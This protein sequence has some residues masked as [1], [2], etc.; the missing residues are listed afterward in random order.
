M[1]SA[2]SLIGFAVAW[3]LATW[4]TALI[5]GAGVAI[6]RPRLAATGPAAERVAAAFVL[7]GAPLGGLVVAGVLIGQSL[8]AGG[9]DHCAMHGHHPH[10]CLFHGEAWGQE[11]WAVVVA[12]LFLLLAGAQLG[13]QVV[14]SWRAHRHIGH[15]AAVG[16]RIAPDVILAPGAEAFC[17]VSGIL[18]PRILVSTTTWEALAE[19]ERVAVLA[20]ERAHIAQRDLAWGALFS[21]ATSTL[22][23][24][25]GRWSITSW[26]RATERLCDARAALGSG[27][28]V[29]A[30]ALLKLARLRASGP[31]IAALRFNA[32]DDV[33]GRA[34]ALLRGAP[35][36][37]LVASRLR[38]GALA[39]FSLAVAMALVL[40]E[41]LHHA[42]E[43]LLGAI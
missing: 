12:S 10:L 3:V 6:L 43:T 8:I 22:P 37:E 9:L 19:D 2:A 38:R 16:R 34:E 15:I 28:D 39:I 29:V 18:R 4:S 32:P 26:R 31:A 21:I 1:T 25:L 40:A 17:F 27:S 30:S 5:L 20:H 24:W 33:V 14:A 23:P 7:L 41:P 13:R 36:G 42:L 11:P 35:H